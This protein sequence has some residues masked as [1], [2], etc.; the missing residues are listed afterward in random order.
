[1]TEEMGHDTAD[2]CQSR[3]NNSSFRQTP[4]E[5]TGGGNS[6]S[7]KNETDVVTVQNL[8]SYGFDENEWLNDSFSCEKC[9]SDTSKPLS[10][11]VTT[12]HNRITGTQ[13]KIYEDCHSTAQAN[14]VSQ[15][16]VR[17][18]LGDCTNISD[19]GFQQSS[20]IKNSPPTKQARQT[21]GTSQENWKP[22]AKT[23]QS[24][25]KTS[26][27]DSKDSTKNDLKH[28]FQ[29][30]GCNVKTSSEHNVNCACS[31]V[32]SSASANVTQTET[33]TAAYRRDFVLS[34][35]VAS[36][37]HSVVSVH[38]NV[39]SSVVSYMSVS[40]SVSFGSPTCSVTAC[41]SLLLTKTTPYRPVSGSIQSSAATELCRSSFA[42][43]QN[44][45]VRNS[46]CTRFSTPGAVVIPSNQSIQTSTMRPTPPMCTCG[47]RAKR[48]FVQSPGQNQGR[49]FFCCGSS[50]RSSRKGC[51]FFRW[52]S[53]PSATPMSRSSQVTPRLTRQ[54]L[55][56]ADRSRTAFATPLSCHVRQTTSS[57]ILVP[58][59]F[60]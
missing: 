50:G 8:L 6:G 46:N 16:S 14:D 19:R 32:L 5:F 53:S 17:K 10:G 31:V 55:H 2:G 39:I 38:A 9:S 4:A 12:R 18:A 20:R 27:V 22:N 60:K 44:P 47:C 48:K 33:I 26:Q 45:C 13:V 24:V 35:T 1:M 49:P 54:N 51:N 58:P 25:Q 40:D 34:S 36:L 28:V 37:M 59:S 57:R 43:P 42:T 52:E 29:A 21:P 56:I 11:A 7:R 15:S 23:S 3:S 41:S 30:G